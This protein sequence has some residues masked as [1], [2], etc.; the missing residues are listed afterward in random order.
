MIANL[1]GFFLPIR[2]FLIYILNNIK[3]L[4]GVFK[5]GKT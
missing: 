3:N 1:S 2:K 4:R 5:N